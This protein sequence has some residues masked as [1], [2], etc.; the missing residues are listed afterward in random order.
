MSTA[1]ENEWGGRTVVKR[2]SRETA[3]A[4]RDEGGGKRA[5]IILSFKY[6][7]GKKGC[8]RGIVRD[9]V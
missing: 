3:D 4:P 2:L 5:E 8:G 7:A 1:Y 6:C 9:A